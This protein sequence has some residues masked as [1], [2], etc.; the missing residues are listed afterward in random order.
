MFYAQI[1]DENICTCVSQLSGEIDNKSLIQ[2]DSYDTSLLGKKYENNTWEETESKEET[3][4]VSDN[5]LFQAEALL[6]QQNII[7]KQNEHD[8]VLAQILLDQQS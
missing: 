8:E 1:N 5:E 3:D 7:I 2:I 6:N 4:D